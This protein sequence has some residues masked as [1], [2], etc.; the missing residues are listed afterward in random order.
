MSYESDNTTIM[1]D[2]IKRQV[3]EMNY[4]KRPLEEAVQWV[5]LRKSQ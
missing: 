3:L 5:F 4:L 2:W 1:P